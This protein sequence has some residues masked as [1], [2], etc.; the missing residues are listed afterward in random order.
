MLVQFA[1]VWWLTAETGSATVLAI[2]TLVATLPGIVIGPVAGAL[3]DRWNRRRVMIAADSVIALATIWLAILFAAGRVQVAHI[4]VIMFIRALGGGFHWP[5]MQAS[6]SLMVPEQH[7]AR[8][9]GLNEMLNGAMNI[10]A[11]PLGA[12]LVTV[13][14]VQVVLALDVVTALVAIV[15]LLF[16]SVPQPVPEPGC[17]SSRSLRRDLLDGLHYVAA[18]PG[19]RILLGMALMIKF[20]IYP[21]FALLPILVTEHFDGG[22]AALGWIESASGVGMVLG[23]TLLGVWGGFRR[24]MV[25]SL[26]GLA[27]LGLGLLLVGLLPGSAFPAALALMGVS[28]ALMSIHSAPLFA[29][30]QATVAP[31]MQGRVLSLFGSI[32]TLAV[33]ISLAIAG[34]LADAWGASVWYVLG[35]G[36][37]VAMGVV[38]LSVPALV[39]MDAAGYRQHAAGVGERAAA[40]AGEPMPEP[41]P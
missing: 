13:L 32:T 29:A 4:Y 26:V 38:G 21:A 14:P 5:A 37:C 17:E 8:V 24:R 7:L 30:L 31:A 23:G 19:L 3:V 15:P 41:Q 27:G 18:W 36:L 9:G 10:A 11:P 39:N 1:L 20:C 34:P 2:G 12:L 6:T 28:G 35:G 25:T 40:T 16:I 22:A 33:P